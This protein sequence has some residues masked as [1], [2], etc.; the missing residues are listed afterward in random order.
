MLEKN[1]STRFD[2]TEDFSFGSKAYSLFAEMRVTHAKYA[3]SKKVEIYSFETK[4]YILYNHHQSISLEEL[5]KEID[6]IKSNFKA[7]VSPHQGH[8]SSQIILTLT[9]DAPLSTEVEKRVR[10]FHYQKGFALGFKGWMDLYVV[11][12]PLGEKRV[13][14]HRKIRKTAEFFAQ[15]Q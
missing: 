1:L 7:L 4:E 3:I 9:T 11:V 6:H 8:R 10:R 2:L 14:A 12:V 15:T 13:I 5:N